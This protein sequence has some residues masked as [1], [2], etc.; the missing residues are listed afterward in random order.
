MKD[1]LLAVLM[2]LSTVSYADTIKGKV[3]VLQTNEPVFAAKIRIVLHDKS[4]INSETNIDGTFEYSADQKTL[5]LITYA[6][7][8]HSDTISFK[9]FDKNN[10]VILLLDKTVFICTNGELKY[11]DEESNPEYDY[12]INGQPT[13]NFTDSLNRRQGRWI[14]SQNDKY[15]KKSKYSFGQPMSIGYY[16]NNLK[17]GKWLILSPSGKIKRKH[18]YN[19]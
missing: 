8:Y 14:I 5:M 16:R 13:T 15:D 19:E 2:L 1:I 4:V 9:Q 3:V 18:L 10:H 7:G 17:V 6:N 11:K 12:S